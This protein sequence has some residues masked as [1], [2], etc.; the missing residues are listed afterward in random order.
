MNL[1]DERTASHLTGDAPEWPR[2]QANPSAAKA[3]N[4]MRSGIGDPPWANLRAGRDE[5][6]DSGAHSAYSYPMPFGTGAASDDVVGYFK[7]NLSAILA[8]CIVAA[9][10]GVAIGMHF[11]DMPSD[12]GPAVRPAEAYLRQPR[13]TEAPASPSD[14]IMLRIEEMRKIAAEDAVDNGPGVAVPAGTAPAARRTE[15]AVDAKPPQAETGS[16]ASL[17]CS[18]ASMA[19]A[20]CDHR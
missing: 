17:P 3:P 12:S 13:Q 2:T 19:L 6:Q 1:N 4:D 16:R 10:I 9:L 8:V 5:L 20:L 11:A 7:N 14:T 15:A 18:A